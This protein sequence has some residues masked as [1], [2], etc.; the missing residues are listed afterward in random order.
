V[1][2]SWNGNGRD[3]VALSRDPAEIQGEGD[4]KWRMARSGEPPPGY[5]KKC[6]VGG[7]YREA[8]DQSD[9]TLDGAGA[10]CGP[11][12]VRAREGGTGDVGGAEAD[13]GVEHHADVQSEVCALLFGFR[14]EGVQWG[15]RAVISKIVSLYKDDANSYDD[16]DDNVIAET[17]DKLE[18]S[19]L[20]I[21]ESTT[22]KQKI[23]ELRS[24]MNE[25]QQEIIN[26]F[27]QYY[28]YYGNQ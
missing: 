26:D 17:L 12:E 13:C 27:L 11:F 3:E 5:D 1:G 28:K 20:S 18:E 16:F 8:Y 2:I 14:P 7:W 23:D 22:V 24:S 25:E 19:L 6:G 21:N 4:A 10:A 15:V 9:T